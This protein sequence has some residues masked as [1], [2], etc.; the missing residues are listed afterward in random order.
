MS[1]YSLYFSPTGGTKK[2]G[3]GITSNIDENFKTIEIEDLVKERLFNAD[4][5]LIVT[6]PCF[7][8]RLPEYCAEKLKLLFGNGAKVVIVSAYGNREFDDQLI[9]MKDILLERGFIIIAAGAF[10]A[11][12]SI[13][14][15][16]GKG[17]P[18]S[19]DINDFKVFA[20]EIKEKLE[21][22][23]N[24]DFEIPGNKPYKE[25]AKSSA[26]P[27]GDDR[28]LFCMACVEGCPVNAITEEDPTDTDADLCFGCQ[29]CIVVCPVECRAIDKDMKAAVTKMLSQIAS[30]RKEN[31]WF[32]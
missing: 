16:Q 12:H 11:Q 21:L 18:D 9:E 32:L 19:E 20:E 2:I 22:G 15:V 3:N 28:C 27:Y 6:M 23:T 5:L 31:K 13:T 24:E 10:I 7:S 25:V 29:R 26:V 17:R 4:D 30:E 14:G 8:G 1:T